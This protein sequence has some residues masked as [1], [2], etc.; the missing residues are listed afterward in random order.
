MVGLNGV[1]DSFALLVLAGDI[2]ADFH[3]GALH[4]VVHRL[5]DVMQQTGAAGDDWV[6]AQLAGHHAGQERHLHGVVEHVLPVTRAVTQPAEQPH[7]LRMDTVQ[8]GLE[9]RALA[10]GFDGGLHLAAGL[11]HRFLKKLVLRV[12]EHHPHLEPDGPDF[13]WLRPDIL[14][15]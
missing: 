13:L 10:L 11:F 5:A 14:S 12:L 7:D 3:V 9:H 8:P 2:H 4:L 15:L 6:D 1:Y